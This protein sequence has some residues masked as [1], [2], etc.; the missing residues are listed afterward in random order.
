MKVIVNYG[1]MVSKGWMIIFKVFRVKKKL[2]NTVITA[3]T[4]SFVD[5]DLSQ[6][7][8]NKHNCYIVG[9]NCNIYTIPSFD[10]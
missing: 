6:Y 9:E 3:E 8:S 1:M 10:K 5:D 4:T 7:R 2:L